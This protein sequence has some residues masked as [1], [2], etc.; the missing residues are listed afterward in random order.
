MK[1]FPGSKADQKAAI[2]AAPWL[3]NVVTSVR[4]FTYGFR[5]ATSS[6]SVGAAITLISVFSFLSP[7]FPLFYGTVVNSLV[8]DMGS[9]ELGH[10]ESWGAGIPF[11]RLKAGAPGFSVG[12]RFVRVW[13]A[14][15][16]G[17]SFSGCFMREVNLVVSTYQYY[18]DGSDGDDGDD[19]GG[20]NE[21]EGDRDVEEILN[22]S[23]IPISC[24]LE[25]VLENVGYLRDTKLSI[26]MY[27]FFQNKVFTRISQPP[28]SPY[29]TSA[30]RIFAALFVVLSCMIAMTIWANSSALEIHRGSFPRTR[31]YEDYLRTHL[32]GYNLHVVVGTIVTIVRMI[33]YVNASSKPG[34][35]ERRRHSIPSYKPG[36]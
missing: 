33:W 9:A 28:I 8:T 27:I 10:C 22:L 3:F 32:M 17:L 4:I 25:V 5:F 19:N 1:M 11:Y 24:F 23:M 29:S 36:K 2:D 16:L 21:E 26:V 12:Q 20:D 6:A 15:I 34:G 35:K 18:D 31:A 30:G 7:P 13:Y 14:P